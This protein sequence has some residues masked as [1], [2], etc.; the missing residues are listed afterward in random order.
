[1]CSKL[2]IIGSAYPR[3][4]ND[5]G[6]GQSQ[7]LWLISRIVRPR[8]HLAAQPLPADPSVSSVPLW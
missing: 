4:G 3:S 5:E 8:S 2:T 7:K 1:M 6:G